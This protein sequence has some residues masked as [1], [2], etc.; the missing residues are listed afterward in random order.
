MKST[1]AIATR[2]VHDKSEL[3]QL[4]R[5]DNFQPCAANCCRHFSCGDA[6]KLLKLQ[7]RKD[8][9]C[10]ARGRNLGLIH[11]D[12]SAKALQSIYTKE[13]TWIKEKS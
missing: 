7:T 3:Q 5:T 4:Y 9:N 11:S 6:P 12:D 2:T 13:T 8:P 1:Q 10:A